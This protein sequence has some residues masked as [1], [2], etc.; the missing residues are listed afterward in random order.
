MN[1]DGLRLVTRLRVTESRSGTAGTVARPGWH[2]PAGTQAGFG[3][4]TGTPNSPLWRPAGPAPGQ[5]VDS[6]AA[7]AGGG[8]RGSRRDEQS[9][10]YLCVVL[11]ARTTT[12]AQRCIHCGRGSRSHEFAS[13]LPIHVRVRRNA[14]R[15][16]G[17]VIWPQ[18][19]GC[20]SSSG[21]RIPSQAEDSEL[22]PDPL[23]EIGFEDELS[24]RP[25]I[26]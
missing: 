5:A 2:G 12:R 14:S 13:S 23:N 22:S 26:Q 20:R 4:V 7:R 25:G 9:R 18:D 10:R 17:Q 3:P 8:G 6:E 21:G 16:G 1:R 11:C 15:A 19:G 24:D